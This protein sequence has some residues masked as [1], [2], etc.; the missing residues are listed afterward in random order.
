M[1]TS[2]LES[3][4]SGRDHY[5]DLYRSHLDREAEWLRRTS[6]QK[7]DSII[8]IATTAGLSPTSVFEVGAGTG[9]VIGS[10][11][12]KGF[13]EAHY[14]VDYSE[15]AIEVLQKAA[16]DVKAAVADITDTPD[17]FGAGPYDL[18]FASHVVEHLEEP[19]PFLR[20]LHAVPMN[21]F[22]AEVPLEDLPAGRLKARVKDR[23]VNA[24]GHVQFFT[25]RSFVDL[26]ERSG[27]RVESVRVYAP[28]LDEE[29]FQFSYGQDSAGRRLFKRLTEFWLPRALGSGWTTLYHAHCTV[30]CT[31]AE[32][33]S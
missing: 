30:L 11:R 24:A 10:L 27:W 18:V 5:A 22:I 32:T 12:Q 9:A 29:T 19:E 6:G 16:P 8:R 2:D 17:P 26:L 21:H 3:G 23:S 1:P 15:E 28:Y 14:A 20:S 31:K 7:T 4:L 25:R 33:G 13:G